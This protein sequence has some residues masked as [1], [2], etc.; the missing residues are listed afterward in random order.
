MITERELIRAI[1][2][3]EQEPH[4]SSKMAKLA[5]FYIIYDHLFGAPPAYDAQYSRANEVETLTVTDGDTEFLRAVNGKN[6]VEAW[7]IMDQLMEA[8]K[9]LQPRMYDQVLS[10]LND[11]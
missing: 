2:E 7:K 11:L 9:V 6:Q 4:T 8:T 1:E 10:M 5:D 3:C